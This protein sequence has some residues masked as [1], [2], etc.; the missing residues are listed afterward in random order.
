MKFLLSFIILLSTFWLSELQAQ[1]VHLSWYSNDEKNNTSN[2]IAVTWMG[3]TSNESIYYGTDS[4]KLKNKAPLE[5]KYSNELGLYTF[6]S[7]IQKLKPDTYYFYRIGTSLA[8]NPVYHFKTAP[9][10][11]T[12]KKVVVGIW[13]DT[14]D[15]KG[16][17]NFVQTDSILGQMAKYP[18][19][20]TL[21]MGDI[22]ENGSVIKSWKKFFDVSQPINANFPFMPVTGNHDV[23][24]DSNNADFQKP[25]PVFYD[26]FNLPENQLNY[27]FDYGNTHFVA[28]NSGVAQ[29]ASLEGKVL[30]G[31]NS[32]EY[33]WLEAD[34]AKA[35]KNKN[36][37][38][39][40]VFCHYPVYAYGVSLVTGWQENLKLLLDKYKVDLCLSGHRHVYERHKA[41]RGADI[42][43]SMDINV[44]DNPKGTVYITNGSAGGSLQGIGG[45]KSSTILFTPSE[46]IYTY[47]VM[48]LDGNEI[49]YEVFDKD[50]RKIDY[51][52]IVK[53]K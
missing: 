47:A 48:E 4:S 46:R 15:N 41:I 52:K 8:Q 37:K 53:S 51:F 7:K 14:Q 21:H 2:S 13:G 32:K 5:I 22:V 45:S 24:N 30:F 31:V 11:G 28:V 1:G 40:V 35:R 36:I 3:N 50:N 27:S 38:W 39:V 29:K 16:N 23:I 17:F 43:E 33:N 42:F 9:K 49:K 12:A 10:V 44:Y 34:L 6:K 18:L 25:F 26:L 20:F 19:H